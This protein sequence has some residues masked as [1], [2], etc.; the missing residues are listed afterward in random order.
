M[1]PPCAQHCLECITAARQPARYS[2][3][4]HVH[5]FGSFL[6]RES[7]DQYQAHHLALLVGQPGE[8]YLD[9]NDIRMLMT[10]GIRNALAQLLRDKDPLAPVSRPGLVD[11]GIAQ[12]AEQPARDRRIRSQLIRTRQSTLNR[13]V[14][15][16]IGVL[17]AAGQV[18]AKRRSRGNKPTICSPR[19]SLSAFMRSAGRC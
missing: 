7:F 3:H 15:E 16:V 4:R 2:S 19:S 13:N 18:R 1:K 14:H 12:N 8:R 10:A 17:H 5:D 6:V 11:P 9:R